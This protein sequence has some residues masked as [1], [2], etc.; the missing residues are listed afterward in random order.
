MKTIKY[1]SVIIFFASAL[2]TLQAQSQLDRE[3]T[4]EREY[5]PSVR[6][7]DK[8]NSLPEVKEPQAP[9]TNVEFS[10]YTLNYLIAPYITNLQ[11]KS[12]FSEYAKH[13]KKGYLNFGVSSLFDLDGDLGYQILNTSQDRLSF[14]YS[15][16]SSNSNVKYLQVDEKQK[17]KLN[18][19]TFGIDFNHFFEKAKFSAD[20]EYTNARYNYYGFSQ[21]HNE[22]VAIDKNTNQSDN[23]FRAH[24]GVNS[25]NAANLSYKFNLHYTF[26]KQKQ[27]IPNDWDAPKENQLMIDFDLNTPINSSTRIGIGGYLKNFSYSPISIRHKNYTSSSFNPYLLF[28]GANWNARVGFSAN[29]QFGKIKNFVVAPDIKLNW[30]PS[31]SVLFYILAT[32]GIQEN[33]NYNAFYENR[34]VDPYCRISDNRTPVDGTVGLNFTLLPNFNIDLFTGFKTTKDEHFFVTKYFYIN[35]LSPFPNITFHESIAPVYAKTNTFKL[36]GALNYAYQDLFDFGIKLIYYNRNIKDSDFEAWNKP[37][38]TTDLLLGFKVP[39]VPLR[40]DANYHLETGRKYLIYNISETGSMDNIHDLKLKANYTLN[41]SF[42]V[43]AKAN[44]LLNQKYDLWYGYPAQG[45]NIMG[46]ISVKF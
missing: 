44:N 38:F 37:T 11:S 20:M 19:N 13:N 23:L 39:S 3:M 17:M 27:D 42:S 36:G 35:H 32:G 8:I 31:E 46:G 22:P 29:K 34:Y 21:Y 14:Y 33:S 41:D 2:F 6:D 7:A 9:K 16:R 26:F 1:I 45:I 15:H 5:N 18:D 30:Y 24:L 25:I 12:Y 43:F 4:L 40:F 10:N 28:D